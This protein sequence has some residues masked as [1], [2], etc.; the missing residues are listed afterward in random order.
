MEKVCVDQVR[1]VSDCLASKESTWPFLGNEDCSRIA[2]L[3]HK[4]EV[5]S[6]LML[7]TCTESLH[8]V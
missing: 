5:A 7:V 2:G 4:K 8:C 6:M 1:N 3:L